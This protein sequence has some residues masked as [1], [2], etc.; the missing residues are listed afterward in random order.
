MRLNKERG[1][2]TKSHMTA[3]EKRNNLTGFLF[4]LPALVLGAI[5]LITPIVMS[6]CFSFT[7]YSPAQTVKFTFLKNY[8]DLFGDELFGQSIVNTLQFV[9]VVVPVQ[10]LIAL[11]LA[12]LVNKQ[13]KGFGI[14]KLAYFAPV[15]TSMT[16]V[17]LLFKMFYGDPDGIF[18]LF[19]TTF[20]LESQGFLNDPNQAMNCIIFMSVWQGAGYQ[21]I[22]L[23]AGLQG[24]SPELYEAASL[25]GANA[26][27]RFK[28]VTL[29]GI[30]SISKFVLLITLTGAFKLFTQPYIMTQ[31][32]PDNKTYTIVYYIYESGLTE[33]RYGFASAMSI[34]FT[35]VFVIA[36]FL[37]KSGVKLVNKYGLYRN[38][39]IEGGM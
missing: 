34:L 33:G 35:L 7:N 14:F 17:A 1:M 5:F 9:V 22:I 19:L 36:S 13:Y 28:D 20:G 10:C 27:H 30:M 11:A 4:F 29:P 37:S 16:V 25:D 31:G 18:N 38:R 12:L 21:M 24:V 6:L 26:W 8:I 15:I 39:K 32:S 2:R 23:L 3:R